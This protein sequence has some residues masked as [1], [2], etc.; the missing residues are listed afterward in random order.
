MQALEYLIKKF[1]GRIIDQQFYEQISL[2][3]EL[4]ME[5]LPALLQ[6]FSA[7]KKA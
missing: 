3:I 7:L 4:P 6:A 2:I 1:N 5:H